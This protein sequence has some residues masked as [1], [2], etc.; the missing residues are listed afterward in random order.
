MP[1]KFV[2]TSVLAAMIA[3]IGADKVH[4]IDLERKVINHHV[5]L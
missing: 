4:R 3:L 5:N 1:G 2:K